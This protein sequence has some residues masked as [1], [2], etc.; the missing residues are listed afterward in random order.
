[1]EPLL[2]IGDR[3]VHDLGDLAAGGAVAWP[4]LK[5]AGAAVI[6]AYDAM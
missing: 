5:T 1:V 3:K 6:A 2:G 4:E